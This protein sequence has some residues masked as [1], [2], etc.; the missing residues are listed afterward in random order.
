MQFDAANMDRRS[1]LLALI[2]FLGIALDPE[3][4]LWRPGA[5]VISIPKPNAVG[6]YDYESI[7]REV[8]AECLRI[9]SHNVRT[10]EFIKR[11]YAKAF[12]S[13][14]KI[15]GALDIKRPIRYHGLA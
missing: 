8:T 15:G 10:P 4:L 7:R 5:K 1:F 13:H 14:I 6:V 12:D 2:A 11:D 3:R 9:L